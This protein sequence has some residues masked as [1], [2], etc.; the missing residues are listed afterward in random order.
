MEIGRR[1]TGRIGRVG[2]IGGIGGEGIAQIVRGVGRVRVGA[3]AVV[4]PG[5]AVC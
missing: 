3:C 1:M 5:V 2:V 4:G